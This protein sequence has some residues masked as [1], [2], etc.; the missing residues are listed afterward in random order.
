MSS[1]IAEAKKLLRFHV[2]R[3]RRKL[4][5]SRAS[6]NESYT[7]TITGLIADRGENLTVAAY[8]PT[9]DEPPIIESLHQL[10]RAGHR[11]LVPR[12]LPRRQLGWVQWHP[13]GEFT[14]NSL[15]INEPVGE[16]LG[17]EAF[18]A[19]DVRLIPALAYDVAGR[20]LGQGGGYYDRLLPAVDLAA[21][22]GK[23]PEQSSNF[24]IVF[25][26]EVLDRLPADTWDAV[27]PHVITEHGVRTLG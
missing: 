1:S 8:L 11:V 10:V 21:E 14:T 27:V 23:S 5:P 19:A 26:T 6:Y 3:S 9:A 2:R 22:T 18:A 7:A 25:A 16:V 20:R 4:A 15:G 17:S 13:D 24:G 12:V